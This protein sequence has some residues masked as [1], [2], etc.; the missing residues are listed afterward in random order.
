MSD[1]NF[2]EIIEIFDAY[3]NMLERPIITE[4]TAEENLSKAFGCC[5]L[6]ENIISKVYQEEKALFFEDN[7]N[8][9]LSEKGRCNTFKC[10]DF[11]KACDKM[12][13][14]YLKDSRVPTSSIDILFNH[15]TRHRGQERLS[16][17]LKHTLTNSMCINSI[18]KSVVE[19]GLPVSD[20]H[21]QALLATWEEETCKGKMNE[22]GKCIDKI[23]DDSHV[24]RLVNLALKND[25]NSETKKVIMKKL[26]SRAFKNDPHFFRDFMKVDAKSLMQLLIDNSEFC[27]NFLDAVFYF[28]R[29]MT[30]EDGNWISEEGIEYN[31]IAKIF[32]ILLEG[33]N[34]VSNQTKERLDLA[35]EMDGK[36]WECIEKDCIRCYRLKAETSSYY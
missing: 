7:L 11:E 20:L 10:S 21:E 16:G 30:F 17:F 28:G 26:T 35:K 33:S 22:V 8:Y 32:R 13:E 6:I 24:L 14:N 19:L 5:Q 23:L 3:L 34:D 27:V 12:L 25:I 15:Y 36:V 31:D 2:D 29:N 4:N 18:L 1:P 9:R